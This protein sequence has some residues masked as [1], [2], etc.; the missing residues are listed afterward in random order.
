MEPATAQLVGLFANVVVLRTDLSGDPTLRSILVGSRD[1]VLDALAHQELPIER[2]VEALNP[3][4]AVAQSVVPEHAQLP[5]EDWALVPR[6]L[7]GRAKP[8]LCHFR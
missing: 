5:G 4:R 8:R 6:D 2:L 3:P 1:T 7:T